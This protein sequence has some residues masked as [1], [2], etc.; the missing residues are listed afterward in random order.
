MILFCA[1]IEENWEQRYSMVWILSPQVSDGNRKTRSSPFIRVP[2]AWTVGRN[3]V[4]TG[5]I[6][7]KGYILDGK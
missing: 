3:F 2:L 4:Q 6:K 1:G 7:R 5:D